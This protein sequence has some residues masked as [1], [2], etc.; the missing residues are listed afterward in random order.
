MLAHVGWQLWGTG[1]STAHAQSRFRAEI[2]R[3][4]FPRV[5]VHAGA[6]G[7]IRISRLALDMAFVQGIDQ[8]ALSRG[9]GHYP[10]TPLPG[11][12]GN[13]AIAGHRTTHLAPFWALD[14]I[15]PGDEITLQTRAGRF[16]YRVQWAILVEPGDWSITARTPLPSLTLTTCAPRFSSRQRLVVR[17]VQVY[18]RTPAGFVDYGTDPHV[19]QIRVATGRR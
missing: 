18:G 14:K 9:P 17:A 11:Q 10:K 2:H 4:G 6:L 12:G 7:Y 13:V 8:D 16:V 3:H 1:I 19:P 15:E 5:P